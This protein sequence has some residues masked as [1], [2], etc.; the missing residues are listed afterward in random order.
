MMIPGSG[1]TMCCLYGCGRPDCSDV[2]FAGCMQL[3]CVP[4]GG[5]ISACMVGVKMLMKD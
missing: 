5:W 3:I 4:F 1:L 2:C